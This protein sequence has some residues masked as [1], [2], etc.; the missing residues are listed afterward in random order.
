MTNVKQNKIMKA[1]RNSK[2]RFFGLY[3]KAGEALN[4][5]FVS[6]SPQYVVVYDRNKKTSR[7]LAKTSLSG[8]KLREVKIG[9][10]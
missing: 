8:L 3:T 5:Q 1:I 9:S 10:V 2:G 7:K 6:E 4:A